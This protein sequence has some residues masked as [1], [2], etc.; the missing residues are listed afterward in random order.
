MLA[1]EGVESD[2]VS[3]AEPSQPSSAHQLP[4]IIPSATDTPSNQ[5]LN[6][7]KKV[8]TDKSN[9]TFEHLASK[10][11]YPFNFYQNGNQPASNKDQQ[12]FSVIN[13]NNPTINMNFNS[14]EPSE[15]NSIR[16]SIRSRSTQRT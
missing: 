16:S 13:F 14:N 1:W 5:V 4:K 6:L 15:L 9:L 11:D 7:G 12:K 8:I 10:T 3:P 2:I